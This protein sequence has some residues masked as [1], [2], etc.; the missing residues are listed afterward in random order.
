MG[1][2]NWE[3]IAWRCNLYVLDSVARLNAF[4][5][6]NDCM[7]CFLTKCTLFSMT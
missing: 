5:E 2:L 3:S 6:I 4:L 7:I 1:F